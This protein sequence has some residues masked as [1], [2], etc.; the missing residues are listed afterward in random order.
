[1][2]E[3]VTISI[4][5]FNSRFTGKLK[6]K[7]SI[8]MIVVWFIIIIIYVIN[9]EKHLIK[10]QK[11]I[12]KFQKWN[13]IISFVM[14][15]SYEINLID[16][17]D[18]SGEILKEKSVKQYTTAHQRGSIITFCRYR[19]NSIFRIDLPTL[20]NKRRMPTFKTSEP[21]KK[22]LH[23]FSQQTILTGIFLGIVLSFTEKRPS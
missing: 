8:H 6:L 9:L 18:E 7:L 15:M 5:I 3:I 22:K 10:R 17:L 1:M 21:C 20:F 11:N 4:K 12:L 23:M 14:K 16:K 13:N 19:Y 2:V